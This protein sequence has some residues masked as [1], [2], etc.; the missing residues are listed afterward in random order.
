MHLRG[1]FVEKIS[2]DRKLYPSPSHKLLRQ[3]S[4]PYFVLRWLKTVSSTFQDLWT[5]MFHY[6]HSLSIDATHGQKF[7][8]FLHADRNAGSREDL[9]HASIERLR[10]WVS[11]FGCK[12]WT[13]WITKNCKIRQQWISLVT[14]TRTTGRRR[15][16]MCMRLN[17]LFRNEKELRWVYK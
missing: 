17:G 8:S 15:E 6:N 10:S 12:N 9:A 4:W 13:R 5:L 16:R 7:I 14:Y 11:C 2:T 3:L 1:F